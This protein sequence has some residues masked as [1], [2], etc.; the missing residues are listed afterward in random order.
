MGRGSRTSSGMTSDLSRK[1]SKRSRNSGS[2]S[3]DHFGER[4]LGRKKGGRKR[5]SDGE[6]AGVQWAAIDII[7][8]WSGACENAIFEKRRIDSYEVERSGK[9]WCTDSHTV[10]YPASN[11]RIGLICLLTLTIAALCMGAFYAGEDWMGF[12]GMAWLTVVVLAI[13]DRFVE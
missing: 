6:G 11:T 2:D 1:R 9:R 10:H 7:R 8:R 12:V 3:K 13:V 4:R 5:S